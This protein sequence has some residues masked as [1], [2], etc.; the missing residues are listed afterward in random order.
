MK[1]K[2]VLVFIL[3]VI[4]FRVAIAQP[5]NA[6]L[7]I[8]PA[9]TILYGNIP[10]AN[11]TL[12]KHLLDIYLPPLKKSKY[13]LIVWVH[14]GAW[15]LNDKYADM[16]YMTQTLKAFADSGYAVASIDYRWSTTVAFPAQV[17]DCNQAVQ[18]LFDNAAKYNLDRGRIALIGFSA[19]GHLASL[20]SLS[21]N[22]GIKSF[23]I[24]GKKTRFKI[25]LCLDFYGPSDFNM[26]TGDEAVDPKSP[27]SLLLGAAV[28]A[29]PDL[30]KTASPATY[31]DKNDPPFLIV[32][33]EKDES[34]NPEQSK[35]LSEKLTK[36]GVKN[37]LIIVPGAPH[38][39]VMFDAENIR[40]RIFTYL[41][42][43]LK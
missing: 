30:A 27:V 42:R 13:P 5:T 15:M 1:S 41:D 18:F 10:Y 29:R 34:V 36:A 20:L 43:Y 39:G 3:A 16:G 26:L 19:G 32:Q 40:K 38:Y 11:D 4:G 2:I 23:Y 17:Q 14:G 33:G 7:S 24:D 12:K 37:E 21:N 25:R 9:G 28:T 8:F 31:I 22:N 35:S 6:K